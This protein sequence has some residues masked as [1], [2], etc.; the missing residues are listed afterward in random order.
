ML[1]HRLIGVEDS[2]KDSAADS[3]LHSEENKVSEVLVYTLENKHSVCFPG[4][5]DSSPEQGDST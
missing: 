1:A 2:N 3:C 4:M 5:V